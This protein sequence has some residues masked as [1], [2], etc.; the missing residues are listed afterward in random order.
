MQASEQA[1]AELSDAGASI[2]STPHR[3]E[4]ISA[5]ESV[6]AAELLAVSQR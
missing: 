3:E 2:E 4:E 1:D 5:L 6:Y